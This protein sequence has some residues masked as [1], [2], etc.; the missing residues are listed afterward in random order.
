M[1]LPTITD[2][3]IDLHPGD[4]LI[5]RYRSWED[6]EALLDRRPD[7]A[8]LRIRYNAKTKEISHSVAFG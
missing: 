5:L 6:Y 4:E 7:K 1:V 3:R 2:D 8:G